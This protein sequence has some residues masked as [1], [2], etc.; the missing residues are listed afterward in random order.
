MSATIISL[1]RGHP[2]PPR[3]A[4]MSLVLPK[5]QPSINKITRQY[6]SI[7]PIRSR[8]TVVQRVTN[9]TTCMDGTPLNHHRSRVLAGSQH[10]T[11]VPPAQARQEFDF[12]KVHGTPIAGGDNVVFLGQQLT[13][14]FREPSSSETR[15]RPPP[16][17]SSSSSVR[18]RPMVKFFKRS[19]S[20]S[21]WSAS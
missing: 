3:H 18:L 14:G 16:G 10:M 15:S 21:A 9:H 7:E 20:M 4:G 19:R 2:S 1:A 13:K 17:P 6:S 11:Q 5:Q 12:R 8:H